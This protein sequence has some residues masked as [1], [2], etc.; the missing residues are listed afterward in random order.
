MMDR[1]YV[2]SF[3]GLWHFP[4]SNSSYNRPLKLAGLCWGSIQFLLDPINT[5]YQI[6]LRYLLKWFVF[7]I[8][9]IAFHMCT[10]LTYNN[11]NRNADCILI[12]YYIAHN[13]FSVE[14]L[15][16]ISPTLLHAWLIGITSWKQAHYPIIII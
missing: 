16:G 15:P 9:T 5:G 2:M 12:L 11:V 8:G 4:P 13:C 3:F 6:M 10:L 7:A 1:G 14:I